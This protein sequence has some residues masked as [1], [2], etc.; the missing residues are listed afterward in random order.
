MLRLAMAMTLAV[1]VSASQEEDVGVRGRIVT[2]RLG[3]E[4]LAEW[5]TT[6]EEYKKLMKSEDSDDVRPEEEEGLARQFDLYPESQDY[7]DRYSDVMFGAGS[8]TIIGSEV[9]KDTRRSSDTRYFEAMPYR[10]SLY[11]RMSFLGHRDGM[12]Y[13]MGH[14]MGHGMGFGR[15][16]WAAGGGMGGMSERPGVDMGLRS[17]MMRPGMGYRRWQQP[18]FYNRIPPRGMPM[19]TR[20]GMGGMGGR[21]PGMGG[22][23]TTGMRPGG[24]PG[25][26]GGMPGSLHRFGVMRHPWMGSRSPFLSGRTNS[27]S[28]ETSTLNLPSMASRS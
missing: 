19:R 2:G 17:S 21:M 6:Y 23:H 5:L 8:G 25:M 11:D 16:P 22:G 13:G 10:S 1:C 14:G 15:H 9:G 4:D 3:V 26:R 18:G 28:G 24:M 12:G 27:V 7:G 20:F